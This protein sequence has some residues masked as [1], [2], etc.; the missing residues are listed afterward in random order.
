MT[1]RTWGEVLPATVEVC[2]I[3]PPGR[4]DRLRETPFT[5]LQALVQTLSPVIQPYLDKCFTLPTERKQEKFRFHL[6][7]IG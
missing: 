3:Q 5:E 6:R 1:Y 4:E 2:P 7:F